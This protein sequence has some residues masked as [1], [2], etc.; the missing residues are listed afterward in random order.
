MDQT[1]YQQPYGDFT[2][3]RKRPHFA[4][5]LVWIS[6]VT[7]TVPVHECYLKNPIH[8]SM[9]EFSPTIEI[10]EGVRMTGVPPYVIRDVE[11]AKKSYQGF[12]EQG[13]LE[14]L[15]EGLDPSDDFLWDIYQRAAEVASSATVSRSYFPY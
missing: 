1:Q 15:K 12:I 3:C 11:G 4:G 10:R 6:D 2:I 5:S 13:N 9:C 8:L 14:F 7:K